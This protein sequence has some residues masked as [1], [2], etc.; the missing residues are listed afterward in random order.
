[1]SSNIGL[2]WSSGADERSEA[3]LGGWIDM[4][5]LDAGCWLRG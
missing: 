5:M 3:G 2:L 1:M 4:R